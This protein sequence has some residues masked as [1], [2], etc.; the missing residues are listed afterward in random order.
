MVFFQKN[1]GQSILSV[2][3]FLSE[4]GNWTQYNPAE[5]PPAQN[6]TGY[7]TVPDLMLDDVGLTL[8]SQDHIL[9]RIGSPE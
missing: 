1:I 3:F 5:V 4:Y 8:F 2:Y 7:L 9:N 6:E